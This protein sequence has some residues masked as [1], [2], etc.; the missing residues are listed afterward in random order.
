MITIV[1]GNL[2]DATEKFLVHQTNCITKRAAHL[3]KDVFQRFPYA[4]VYTG[5]QVADHPGSIEIRGNGVDQRY[6]VN[7]FGQYYPGKPKNPDLIYD[8]FQTRERYFY[9]GLLSLAKVSDLESVAMPVGIGCGAAGGNWNTYL[10]LITKFANYIEETQRAQV[11]L[12][13]LNHL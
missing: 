13:D 9:Q 7:L 12:Y 2:L 11:V 5:R 6:V 3:S 4:D 1:K 8:G 10:S